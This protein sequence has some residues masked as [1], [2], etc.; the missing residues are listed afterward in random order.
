MRR[1]QPNVILNLPPFY[2]LI[3]LEISGCGWLMGFTKTVPHRRVERIDPGVRSPA[4]GIFNLQA[5]FRCK[6]AA[7]AARENPAPQFV[8]G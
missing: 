8:V 4:G 6:L 3:E 5:R 1:G 2:V 7:D